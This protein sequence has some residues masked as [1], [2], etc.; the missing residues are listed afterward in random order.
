MVSKFKTFFKVYSGQVDKFDEAAYWRLSDEII[1]EVV[2]RNLPS[3]KDFVLFDAGGGTGRWSIIVNKMKS[4]FPIIYDLS[5][6]ML[7][8]AEKNVEKAGIRTKARLIKGNLE[9]IS[10]CKDES[11]DM[12]IGIYNVLSF[13][14]YPQKAIGELYRILK[15]N[16]KI[17]IMAQSYFNAIAEKIAAGA[18]PKELQELEERAEVKWNKKV[19]ALKVYSK[20]SLEKLLERAKFVVE[21]T[22]GI[23]VLVS[24]EYEDFTYPYVKMSNISKKLEDPKFFKTIFDLEK[25]FNSNPAVVNGGVNLLCVARKNV[26]N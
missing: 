10:V 3:K 6:D 23:T 26:I 2:K 25:K 16:G 24:P 11:A 9:N 20:M 15:P 22:Y 13:I 19:P 8:V 12:I 14:N 17:L 21:K 1:K 5:A 7:S 18:K 4:C